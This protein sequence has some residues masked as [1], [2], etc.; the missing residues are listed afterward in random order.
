MI[1]A[2]APKGRLESLM[3]DFTDVHGTVLLGMHKELQTLKSDVEESVG[4]QIESVLREVNEA[5]TQ[6]NLRLEHSNAILDK[7]IAQTKSNLT[8]IKALGTKAIEDISVEKTSGL[9]EL[10]AL[11]GEIEQKCSE[12]QNSMQSSITQAIEDLATARTSGLAE[13]KSLLSEIEQSRSE[14]RT[15]AA[16]T[17][18]RVAGITSDL[19]SKLSASLSYSSKMNSESQ[20]ILKKARE[21]QELLYRREIELQKR[22]KQFT[23]G[24]VLAVLATVIFWIWL[25]LNH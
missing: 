21:R 15:E 22:T 2:S 18:Q 14:F 24:A 10:K 5:N 8:S 11:L 13:L 9:T 6:L 17:Q 19:Q 16:N 7:T 23:I 3:D 1:E 25:A 20:R 4:Q 12:F